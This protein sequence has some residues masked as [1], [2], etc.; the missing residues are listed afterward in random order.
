MPGMN[1]PISVTD[2]FV[3]AL[4]HHR[5]WVLFSWVLLLTMALAA[6]I[7][8]RGRTS[9]PDYEPRAR[10]WVRL[11]FG[12]LWLVDGLLQLQAAMPLGMANQVV[13]PSID[14][15]P[16]WLG[17]LMHHAIT[18]YN[19]HPVSLAVAI[20]WIQL[21]L[22]AGLLAT[23]GRWSRLFAVGSVAWGLLVWLIG[24]GAGGLFSGS[25]SLLFGWPGAVAFYVMA[26]VWLAGPLRWFP[27]RFALVM[28]RILA[29]ILAGGAVLQILPD[30]GFWHAGAANALSTMGRSMSAVAQPGWIAAFVRQSTHV[31]GA[32]GPE[33]NLLIVCWLVVTGW[34]L[35]RSPSTSWRWPARS[36]AIGAMLWWVVA[37]DLAVFGGLGTDVNSWLPIAALGV[38]AA[39]ARRSAAPAHVPGANRLRMVIA[40]TLASL[41]LAFGVV[42]VVGA[43]VPLTQP[44]ETTLYL[45]QNGAWTVVQLPAPV[46]TLYD[47]NGSAYT[48]GKP[49]HHWMMVTFLDPVCWTDCPLLAAQFAQVAR[50]T[51]TVPIDFVAIAA[52]PYHH[53]AS[54]LR[55]FMRNYHLMGVRNFHFLNGTT[56]QLQAAWNSYG[57]SVSSRPTDKM[58]VHSDT[59]FVLD[60]KG[61][62]RVVVPDDPGAGA[63]QTASSVVALEQ[64]LHQVGLH[65]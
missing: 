12:A 54:E 8:F 39:P 51:G 6:V 24:N 29:V 33:T 52:N 48:I 5:L 25:A 27:E 3:V 15:T 21:S 31:L 17:G 28:P 16:S 23:R 2:P 57:I 65:W 62:L 58:A 20:A 41:A 49:H 45:A 32:M 30:R 55:A 26:G 11:S 59:A 56:A 64:A 35:W 18:L 42:G 37:Q 9:E 14:G 13:A 19:E 40:G 43:V 53:K 46:V 44:A 47:L 10:T 38:A 60:P 36:L 7:L 61:N 1:M 4:F 22:G 50:Q 63:A 34:G